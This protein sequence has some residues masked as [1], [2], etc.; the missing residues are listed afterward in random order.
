[1][2]LQPAIISC[3][4]VLDAVF[5]DRES[6]PHP[7]RVIGRLIQVLETP[8]RRW[9]KNRRMAGVFMGLLVICSVFGCTH[10]IVAVTTSINPYF[11]VAISIAIIYTCLSTRCLGDEA[12]AIVKKLQSGDMTTA[13]RSLARIVGRDT[14][15]LN[16][17]EIVRATVE[18]VSENIVDGIISPIFFAFLG[19]A[20]LAMAYK[21]INTLDSMIGYKDERYSE[22]G[23]FSA[24]L[25]DGANFIPAR[26]CLIIIPLAALLLFPGRAFRILQVMLRDGHKSP[27][28]N[29][30]YPESG[31]AAAL[32]IKLGGTCTYRGI[33]HE[34][35]LLG[36]G[37]KQHEI[38]DI[39]G[40]IKLMWCSSITA[41]VLFFA[42]SCQL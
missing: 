16:Q 4:W 26:L 9:I 18:T 17:E 32:G 41:L 2:A 15:E 37:E 10:L 35:P 36:D 34:K 25:D 6:M 7:V 1:M 21:A 29:A 33:T 23:W 20:P 39:N 19:G 5:G 38:S 3:A 8:S 11:G 27:S 42:L 22:F 28:P 13:R 31:F 12:R 40:A 30:G 24:R 14:V